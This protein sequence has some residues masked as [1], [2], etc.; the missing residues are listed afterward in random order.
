[1]GAAS[2]F[3]WVGCMSC[4]LGRCRINLRFFSEGVTIHV[5]DSSRPDLYVWQRGALLGCIPYG[6]GYFKLKM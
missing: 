4:P 2:F 1:M 6:G 5:C 3:V